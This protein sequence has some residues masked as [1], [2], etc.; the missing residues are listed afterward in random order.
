MSVPSQSATTASGYDMGHFI[1]EA[2][3]SPYP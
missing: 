2:G 3:L 1:L